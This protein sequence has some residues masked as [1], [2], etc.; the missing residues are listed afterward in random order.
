MGAV[1]VSRSVF[2]SC[3]WAS[4][5][6]DSSISTEERTQRALTRRLARLDASV[7]LAALLPESVTPPDPSLDDHHGSGRDPEVETADILQLAR[8]RQWRVIPG[9]RAPSIGTK[10]SVDWV[11][12]KLGVA[13]G[14]EPYSWASGSS[15]AHDEHPPLTATW[16]EWSAARGTTPAWLTILWSSGVLFGPRLFLA[17]FERYVHQT[18]LVEQYR[19]LERLFLEVP[20][21]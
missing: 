3:L 4:A 8:D 18:V 6:I 15:M 12:K 21:S 11:A 1:S 9:Q 19:E 2:E 10:L 5:L 17:S 7:R 13:T 20:G 14:V 16:V